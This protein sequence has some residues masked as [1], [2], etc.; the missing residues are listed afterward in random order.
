MSA[1]KVDSKAGNGFVVDK[2]LRF[3]SGQPA[4]ILSSAQGAGG[5]LALACQD[6]LSDYCRGCFPGGP[7]GAEANAKRLEV[8][9]QVVFLQSDLFENVSVH[10]GLFVLTLHTSRDELPG[11]PG[12]QT[13]LPSL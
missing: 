11:F 3:R 1:E 6:P 7:Q 5:A 13:E 10:I 9:S 4:N 8:D 2:T 12:V